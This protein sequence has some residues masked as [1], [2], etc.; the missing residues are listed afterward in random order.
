MPLECLAASGYSVCP[1]IWSRRPL[2]VYVSSWALNN[3]AWDQVLPYTMSALQSRRFENIC[4]SN[5]LT[6]AVSYLFVFCFNSSFRQPCFKHDRP[7]LSDRETSGEF[8]AGVYTQFTSLASER[9]GKDMTQ[10]IPLEPGSSSHLGCDLC[11]K[12]ASHLAQGQRHGKISKAYEV[13]WNGY[14]GRGHSCFIIYLE[15]A[16]L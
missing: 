12:G 13:L 16:M 5:D 7:G 9:K 11:S 15:Q 2:L 8:P 14:G 6:G 10:G 3:Q 1:N 4:W